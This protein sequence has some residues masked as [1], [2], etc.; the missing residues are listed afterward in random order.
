M[1]SVMLSSSL[2]CG[3]EQFE[4]SEMNQPYQIGLDL[5]YTNFKCLKNVPPSPSEKL[6]HYQL[7][8]ANVVDLMHFVKLT[9]DC[10]LIASVSRS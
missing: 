8:E 3:S 5:A 1:N 2:R 10:D 7:D 6:T 4:A 9:V